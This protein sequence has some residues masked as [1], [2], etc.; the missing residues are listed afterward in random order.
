MTRYAIPS[1][2]VAVIVLG[3]VAVTVALGV[4]LVPTSAEATERGVYAP[5]II[6][7]GIIAIT[8]VCGLLLAGFLVWVGLKGLSASA[9]AAHT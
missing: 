2:V 3:I 5:W 8:D 1:L 9:P 7:W 6:V 4:N